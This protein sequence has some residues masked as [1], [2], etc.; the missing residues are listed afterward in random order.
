VLIQQHLQLLQNLQ[1]Y[2]KSEWRIPLK[3]QPRVRKLILQKVFTYNKNEQQQ[4]IQ[5]IQEIQ[6]IQKEDF[7]QNQ[8]P[9]QT[10][11]LNTWKSKL[12]TITSISMLVSTLEIINK[13]LPF[14]QQQQQSI[15]SC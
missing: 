12:I 8:K 14:Q 7:E 15:W 9:K 2:K 6:E 4:K 11:Y 10:V 13:K 5:E 1:H 3:K